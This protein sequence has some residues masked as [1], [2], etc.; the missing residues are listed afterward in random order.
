MAFS[1][2]VSVA[3]FSVVLTESFVAVAASTLVPATFLAAA[4][5]ARRA[6][7]A[8]GAAGDAGATDTTGNSLIAK[9]PGVKEA[10]EA[11]RSAIASVDEIDLL[12]PN[13]ARIEADFEFEASEA[14]SGD[15]TVGGFVNVVAISA[16][17][18]ALYQTS[19][20]N[21][22]HLEVDFA[23]VNYKLTPA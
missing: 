11:L 18:S 15:A 10:V 14:Y 17:Y 20:R 1:T 8:S 19:T 6:A 12:V 16:G 2:A 22:I 3:A 13:K 5:A 7:D 21:K 23:A 4:R 9:A